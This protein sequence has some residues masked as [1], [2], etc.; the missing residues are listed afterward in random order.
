MTLSL[1]TAQ[2]IIDVALAKGHELGIKPLTVAVLDAGGHLKA[3]ARE[4]GTSTLRPDIAEG[5]ANGALALG[6]GSRA[7][8][9][10][11]QEQPFF[12]QAMNGLAGGSLVPVP[13][14]VLIRDDTGIIGAVGVTGDTSDND[15]ICAIAGVEAAGLTADA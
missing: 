3:M 15:E 12:I 14:G 6:I 2:K 11:A 7:I 5:K 1:E 13:G 9:N 8:F 10:R 4:D